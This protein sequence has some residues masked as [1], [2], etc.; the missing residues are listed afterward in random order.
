MPNL[1]SCCIAGH[2]GRDPETKDIK[3]G[4][5]ANATVAVSKH[6][7]KDGEWKSE[8]TWIDITAFGN[9]AEK[10]AKMA[11]GNSIFVQGEFAVNEWETQEG[12]K[13]RKAY[14]LARSV[15]NLTPKDKSNSSGGSN[16]NQDQDLPF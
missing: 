12:E 15:S 10:L 14:I 5:L 16:D 7:Q 6:F 13:R 11:K 2:L 1:N 3:S 8:T 9:T 4:K